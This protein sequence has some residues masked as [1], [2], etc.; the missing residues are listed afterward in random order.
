M[1]MNMMFVI[2]GM[3]LVTYIPRML[4]LVF[5]D[6]ERIPTWVQAILRNVPYAALGALIFPGI[7]TVH[8]NI[9]YGIIGGITAVIVAY[10]GA[11]LIIVVMS[12]IVMLMLLSVFV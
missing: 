7:L 12:S 1:S 5:L 3:A 2:A 10:L 11:N 8:E 4:P 9:W 6:I